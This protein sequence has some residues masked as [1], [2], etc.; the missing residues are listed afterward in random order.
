MSSNNASP[1][2]LEKLF[3]KIK[4]SKAREY[5]TWPS[6]ETGGVMPMSIE[7]RFANERERLGPD[8]NHKWRKWRAQYLKDQELHPQEPFKVPELYK[9]LNNPIRRFYKAPWNYFEEKLL[10]PK[11]VSTTLKEYRLF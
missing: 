5:P 7:S 11:I 9:E 8:F 6:S 10:A 4:S 3:G 2:S 1:S